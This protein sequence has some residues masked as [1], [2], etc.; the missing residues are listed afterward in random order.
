VST[1]RG[2][3]LSRAKGWRLPADAINVAR[4]TRWGNPYTEKE[5]GLDLALEMYERSV[6]G[7]WTPSGIPDELVDRAYA[8]HTAF[9]GRFDSVDE[10]RNLRGWSLACWCATGA[11]CHRDILLRLANGPQ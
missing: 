1:P 6:T 4:P 9:R 2:I 8:L 3:Q 11:R 5:F 7:Y 10:T